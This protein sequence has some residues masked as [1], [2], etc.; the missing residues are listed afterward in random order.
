[1]KKN[2]FLQV[3]ELLHKNDDM[4]KKPKNSIIKNIMKRI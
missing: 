3:F 2:N 1:M 4:Q